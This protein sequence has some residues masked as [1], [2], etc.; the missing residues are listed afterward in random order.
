MRAYAIR[1]YRPSIEVEQF[2]AFALADDCSLIT[3]LV[4]VLPLLLFNKYIT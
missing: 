2:D 3:E 4:Y 1:P